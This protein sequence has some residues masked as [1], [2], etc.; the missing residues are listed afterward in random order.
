METGR[1]T[2]FLPRTLYEYINGA[3]DLYLAYE[4]LDLQWPNTRGRRRPE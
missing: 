2:G 4:F 3:A 1:K